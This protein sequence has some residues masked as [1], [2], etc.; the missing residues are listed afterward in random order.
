MTL[1]INTDVERQIQTRFKLEQLKIRSKPVEIDCT[2]SVR[3]IV[4]EH[5]DFIANV[6]IVT[7]ANK[8]HGFDF[9]II[10][11]NA[12]KIH[13]EKQ[14]PINFKKPSRKMQHNLQQ[15]RIHLKRKHKAQQ[16]YVG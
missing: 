3:R 16:N 6:K 7:F 15:N 11:L 4:G 13:H 9:K 12:P 14:R 2:H 10:R 1:S 8:F 5:S